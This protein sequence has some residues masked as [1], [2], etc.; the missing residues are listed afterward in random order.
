M[1]QISELLVSAVKD[2]NNQPSDSLSSLVLVDKAQQTQVNCL[3]T[4]NF[5]ETKMFGTTIL[6][7]IMGKKTTI[8]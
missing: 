6:M 4:G 8:K 2:I 1:Q 3:N 7:K 5:V